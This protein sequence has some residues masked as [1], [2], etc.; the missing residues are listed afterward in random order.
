[1]VQEVRI[2]ATGS[3]VRHSSETIEHY[4]P[5]EIVEPARLI[6]GGFDL[7]PASTG[8][9]NEFIR[10][11]R[12][13]NVRSNGFK[14]PWADRVWLNPP[15][16]KCDP[17]GNPLVPAKKFIDG[18]NGTRCEAPSQSSAKSWWIKLAN[19]YVC[20][21]TTQAL[22]VGF[23]LEILQTTQDV[24]ELGLPIPLD[25]ALCYPKARV[26]YMKPDGTRGT[27]PPHASVL[28]Y[29]GD[30]LDAFMSAYASLG[31]CVIPSSRM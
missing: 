21:R 28:I 19:E 22:F 23:S 17:D 26:P 13:F 1:M 11:D 3:N 29:L 2:V 16:G 18:A 10:A 27:A 14:Q 6:M 7:D 25:F 5:P 4:S 12:Y 30:R 9:A 24:A 31:R 20:K 15:G 8:I